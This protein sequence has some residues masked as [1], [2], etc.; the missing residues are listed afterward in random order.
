MADLRAKPDTTG[1]ELDAAIADCR[2]RI[3]E[4]GG[5]FSGG[6]ECAI[7]EIGALD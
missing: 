6:S 5:S 3:I 1:N 2:R 7:A 4:A